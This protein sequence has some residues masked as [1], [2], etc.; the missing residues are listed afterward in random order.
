MT[1]VGDQHRHVRKEIT[2]QHRRRLQIFQAAKRA[3]FTQ[4]HQPE[5]IKIKFQYHINKTIH[6]ND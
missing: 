3:T 1:I 6:S 5:T 2:M 4:Q